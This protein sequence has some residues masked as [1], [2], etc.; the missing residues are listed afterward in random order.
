MVMKKR[1]AV[2]LLM[3]VPILEKI[4]GRVSKMRPGPEPGSMPAE[5]TAGITA[6]PEIMAK[7]RSARA[8]PLLKTKMF[9]SPLT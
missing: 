1:M 7:A 8:V 3:K 4:Y 6:N 9:S 2:R 5:K